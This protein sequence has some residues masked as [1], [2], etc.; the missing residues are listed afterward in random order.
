MINRRHLRVKV[1][2][3]LYAYFQ[4]DEEN[5]GETEKRLLRSIEQMYDLYLL[6]M[7]TFPEL[8]QIA[9]LRMEDARNKLRPSQEDLNPNRKFVDNRIIELIENHPGLRVES[10]KRKV[11]WVGD[12]NR[13]MFRKMFLTIKDSE[14]YFNFMNNGQSGF[15]EDKAFMVALFKEEIA[16]SPL[17]YN[18]LEE[19]SIGWLDD[20]DLMCSMVLKTIKSFTEEGPNSILPLYKDPVDERGFITT[21]L[22]KSIINEEV[23]SK[24]I[25][26]LTDNWELDRIAK[27]DVILMNMALTELMEFPSIP[28]KVTMNEYIEI[29]KFY[30]TPKSNTFINGILDKAADQ[31]IA[32]GKIKKVGR[33][34]ME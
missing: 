16:N 14:T 17:L 4:S 25:E 18:F 22:R 24:L 6:L 10:E 15:D 9:S 2:Q 12:V 26:S 13:E 27:M 21:L 30:S 20:I 33:G 29:S 19:K 3:A 7:L 5:Y 11:N 8:K 1:L 28:K 31:L 32:E 34:L 23:N